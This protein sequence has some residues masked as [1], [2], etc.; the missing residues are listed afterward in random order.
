MKIS[1][2]IWFYSY[3][4]NYAGLIPLIMVYIASMGYVFFDVVFSEI[5]KKDKK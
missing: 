4:E 2:V 5:K 1:D 3:L